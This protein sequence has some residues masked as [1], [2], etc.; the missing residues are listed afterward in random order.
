MFILV[1]TSQEPVTLIQLQ[2]VTTVR[3]L[4]LVVPITQRAT[5]IQLQAVTMAVVLT[6]V[7]LIRERY[8]TTI[9]QQDATTVRVNT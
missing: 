9:P 2:V 4:T 8:V 6:L 5:T 1:A 3:V 7:V